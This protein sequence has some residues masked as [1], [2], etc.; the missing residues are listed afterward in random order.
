MTTLSSSLAMS[1]FGL[2]TCGSSSKSRRCRQ[3]VLLIITGVVALQSAKLFLY[4]HHTFDQRRQK[5]LGQAG[6]IEE[7]PFSEISKAKM[8]FLGDLLVP[9][10][11]SNK[12]F[13]F[14]VNADGDFLQRIHRF[15]LA[16]AFVRQWIV[17]EQR[18]AANVSRNWNDTVLKVGGPPELIWGGRDDYLELLAT[19][20]RHIIT[21][22]LPWLI[23]TNQK[24]TYKSTDV[25]DWHTSNWT[26][27]TDFSN[28]LVQQYYGWSGDDKLCTLIETPGAIKMKYDATYNKKCDRNRSEATS[29]PQ[30][31]EP[32]FL[33][34]KPISR[35]QYWPNDGNSYPAHFYTATPPHVL[36][37]HIHTDAV[38]SGDGDVFSGRSALLLY[39]CRDSSTEP[40]TTMP[41]NAA[42]SALY[43]EVLTLTQYWSTL[44]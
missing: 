5:S 38:V 25:P 35:N 39:Q 15:N 9:I 43:D 29:R 6:T 13:G 26:S 12:F 28:I 36:L 4:Q 22:A 17:G 19:Q 1:G 34:A 31:L 32:M 24:T 16:L 20:H 18:T 23:P 27:L 2:L 3:L 30:S 10:S 21:V 40:R 42:T 8:E 14:L 41:A 33:N 11:K 7:S 37:L 44:R